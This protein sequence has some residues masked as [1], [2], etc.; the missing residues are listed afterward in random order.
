MSTKEQIIIER[1]QGAFPD[2]QIQLRDTNGGGSHWELHICAKE[3]DGLSRVKKH[4]AIYKPLN[5]MIAA[6]EVHALQINT[7]TAE[8]WEQ[9]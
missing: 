2:A 4:Q 5:D 7:Y 3:L 1:L 8:A 6:N 9:R